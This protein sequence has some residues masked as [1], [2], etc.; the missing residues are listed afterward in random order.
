MILVDTSVWIDFLNGH[1]SGEAEVLAQLI[2]ENQAITV[3]GLVLTEILCGLR[4][5]AEAER[6]AK[7]LSAFAS[8]P[9]PNRH[10]YLAAAGIYRTCRA[11]GQTI[12]STIDCL[13]ARICLR[14]DC[15]LLTKD[16][17]FD[18]IARSFPLERLKPA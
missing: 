13:I 9:E 17:D 3:P 18:A 14:D 4:S 16:R 12:R 11:Q 15:R 10:D 5:D 8:T 6:I 1:A 2:E 7:L